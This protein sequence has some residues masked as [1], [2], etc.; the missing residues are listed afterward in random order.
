MD[1]PKIKTVFSDTD[2]EVKFDSILYGYRK[3]FPEECKAFIK[4]VQH[5]RADLLSSSAISEGGHFLYKAMIPA[6]LLYAIQS[7]YWR[8]GFPR[9]WLDDPKFIHKFLAR[10]KVFCINETSKPT[11]RSQDRKDLEDDFPHA[12]AEKY[13]W[14]PEDDCA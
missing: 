10:A 9:N 7:N 3:R 11:I 12:H 2:L 13:G 1:A 6:R 5:T 4:A 14:G 8:L